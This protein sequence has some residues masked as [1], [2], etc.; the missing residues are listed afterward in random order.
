[1]SIPPGRRWPPG[2]RRPRSTLPAMPYTRMMFGPEQRNVM[3]SLAKLGDWY[4]RGPWSSGERDSS[5]GEVLKRLE[6]RGY[7]EAYRRP[8]GVIAFR[9]TEKGRAAVAIL[10]L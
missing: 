1:M 6:R 9:I 7:C 8:D 10:K 5:T 4:P 3:G 2:S